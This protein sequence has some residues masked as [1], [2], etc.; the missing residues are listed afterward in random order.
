MYA[1][2]YVYML[3]ALK[4][5]DRVVKHYERRLLSLQTAFAAAFTA[6]NLEQVSLG[7]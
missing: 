4:E 3:Q 7:Q 5:A 2:M 1:R 6:R